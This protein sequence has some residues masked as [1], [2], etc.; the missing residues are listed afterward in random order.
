MDLI[1]DIQP[2][3]STATESA[4]TGDLVASV[5]SGI[6]SLTAFVPVD[7]CSV[8]SVTQERTAVGYP[9]HPHPAFVYLYISIP[10]THRVLG[11]GQIR[12]WKF[13]WGQMGALRS[14]K[15]IYGAIKMTRTK[16]S[17]A[18]I[19]NFWAGGVYALANT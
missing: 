10:L 11:F 1:A 12:D 9:T 4:H 18:V 8:V 14:Q 16:R 17:K 7:R 15:H 2:L 19:Q 6:P 5:V 13:W 3:I